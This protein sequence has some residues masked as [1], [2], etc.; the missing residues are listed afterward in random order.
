[1]DFLFSK[2]RDIPDAGDSDSA[3]DENQNKEDEKNIAE[4]DGGFFGSGC[5]GLRT[6][7]EERLED[8]GRWK[9]RA[10]PSGPAGRQKEFRT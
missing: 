7:M 6:P 5:R 2:M 8:A 1:M 9:V 3:E 10:G 4:S